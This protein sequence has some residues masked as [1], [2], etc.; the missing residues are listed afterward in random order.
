M[1]AQDTNLDVISNNIANINTTAFK[2]VKANFQDLLYQRLSPSGAVDS[3]NNRTPSETVVGLGVQLVNTQRD[4]SEG[5]LEITNNRFDIAI[6]GSGFFQVE[7][8]E[9]MGG[10]GYG[11]TRDGNFL[12][13]AN[14]QLVTAQGYK[15]V[16]NI[17]LPQDFIFDSVDIAEDGTVSVGTP[18][19]TALQQVGQI[20]L[21]AFVNTEGLQSIGQNLYIETDASG[22]PQT[23]AAGTSNLG[24]IKQ[25]HLESSNVDLVT[26][27]VNLIRT[28]RAYEFNSQTIKTADEMMQVVST[29][30]R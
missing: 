30:R 21:A 18:G 10:G 24:T 7:V 9:S 8:P 4:F 25:G 23:G 3:Q 6:M 1:K 2:K 29:L 17:T 15:L 12:P 26:E 28:Q 5:R 19:S 16:P 22:T 27:L 20:E 11:Y 14:G 13:D